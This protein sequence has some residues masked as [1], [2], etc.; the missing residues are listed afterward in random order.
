[1]RPTAP[2]ASKRPGRRPGRGVAALLAAVVGLLLLSAGPARAHAALLAADPPDGARLDESP[3]QVELSFSEAVSASLGGIRVLDRTGERVDRGAVR[4]A[5]TTVAVDLAPDLPDGTYVITYRIV[6][7]DGHPVRGSSVFGVGEGA[8]DP[9]VARSVGGAG[10]DRAWEVVR[11]IGQGLAYAGTLLAAGGAVFLLWAHRGGA[12]RAALRR[13]VRLAAVVGGIGAL[14]ALPVQAALGTGKGAGAL[15]ET[16]VLGAVVDDGVGV[17]IGLC[18]IGLA[19]TVVALDRHRLA[20]TVGAAVASASFAATG[21]TRIGDVATLGTIAD[22]V[23]LGVVAV[24]GGGA[25]LLWWTLRARRRAAAPVEPAD[26]AGVVLRFSGLATLTVVAAGATG[27]FLGWNEVRSLDALTGTG[28]GRLLLAKVAA[29][30]VVAGLGAYNH[31]RL[32]PAL[33]QGK[34]K[35]ALARLATTVRIE[36]LVLVAVVALTSVLVFVTPAR[37]SAEGGP[38]ERIIQLSGDAGSVQLVV[39][40]ARVGSNQI[41]L[42]TFDPEGRPTELAEE[43]TLELELPAAQLGPIV[44]TATRAGPAH[45]QVD[46]DDLAVP[47]TWRI[48]VRLRLDRFTEATGTAEV[49]VAG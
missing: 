30:A 1:M 22:A 27:A 3:A 5:G 37:T 15:F 17:A 16:G 49:P 42:Y 18:L 35:A 36:A 32:L 14:V 23:H 28:Y 39:A 44:R 19:V 29:V 34:A 2:P 12:E 40:P 20:A 45:S 24:W 6:S 10:S 46:G 8:V 4:V 13:I 25:V 47:G 11:S 9:S 31:F 26:T 21:H 43:I 48:T 7:A 38:V 41:H 33:Q